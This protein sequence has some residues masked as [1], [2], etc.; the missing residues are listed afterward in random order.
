MD[1]S[2]DFD[3]KKFIVKPW[4]GQ[5]GPTFTRKF[6]P[7]FESALNVQRDSFS[8]VGQFLKGTDFGGWA[9]GAPIHIAGAGALAAQNAM[10]IQSRI[11]RGDSLLH[12][13]KKHILNEDI[14]DAIDAQMV[15]LVGAAPNPPPLGPGGAA[16]V[17]TLPTDWAMQLWLWIEQSHGQL[18]Q[19]GLLHSNQNDEWTSVKIT[20]VGIDRD[21]PRRLYGHLLRLNRARQNA[22]PIIEVWTK[23]LK[24]FT[25]P[26]MLNDM[27]LVQMQNPTY[28]IIGGPNAG[29]PDLGALVTVFEELWATI[30]NRGVEIKPQAP[31][32][33]QGPPSNRV[34][35]MHV[36]ITST[37]DINPNAQLHESFAVTSG[38]ETFPFLKDERN[39]WKC[40]GWGHT[41]EDCTSA[42]RP[43]PLSGCIQGLQE[44][45]S[46]QNARLRSVQAKRPQRR[47]GPSPGYANRA[48][49][50]PNPPSA[51]LSASADADQ[52]PLR[53]DLIEYDDGGVFTDQ[54][55]MVVE[56]EWFAPPPTVESNV[57]SGN[58]QSA[59]VQMVNGLTQSRVEPE[60]LAQNAQLRVESEPIAQNAQPTEPN[61]Q[62]GAIAES[63]TFTNIDEAIEREFQS[64]FQSSVCA[65]SDGPVTDDFVKFERQLLHRVGRYVCIASLA[66]GA[67]AAAV[68]STRGKALFLTLCALAVPARSHMIVPDVA[69]HSSEFSSRNASSY[70]LQA[71]S[72]QMPSMRHNA[73]VDSG[74]TECASGRRK[75]F[76]PSL[77]Q[78]RNPSV[79][80]E[81][82]SGVCLPVALQGG[83]AIK[84]RNYGTTS[85]KKTHLLIV[86]N[87]FF[88]PQMPVT[89]ISTKALFRYHGIRTYFNDELYLLLPDGEKLGFVETRNNYTLLIDDDDHGNLDI[90]REPS[91]MKSSSGAAINAHFNSTLR[92]P[93]PL[94]WT[95]A[96]SRFTHFSP[97]RVQAS[98]EYL[99]NSGLEKLSL[100]PRGDVPCIGCVKGGFRGHRRGHRPRGQFTRFGQRIYSDSC[101]MPKSTPF[102]YTY[103]YIFYDAY[104]KLI[105]VYFGKS[106]T[107]AEMRHVFKQFLADYGRYMKDGKVEEWY[108]DGGP[109]FSSDDTEVFCA[110]M[111]TRL[112]LIAPWNP[113]MNVAETGWR[114]ILRPL[115]ILIAASNVSRRLWP[116][117]VA[118]I[119]RVH[120]ALSTASASATEGVV[121]NFAQA[122]IA[123]LSSAANSSSPSPWYLVT[124]KKYDASLLRVMFCECEVRIRSKPD[125]A[126]REKT[127]PITY[128]AMHLGI[129]SKCVGF[130]VY[131]FC[132]HRFTTASFNDVYFRENKYPPLDVIVGTF[133]LGG[134]EG[135]LPTS[136]QQ[137][138]DTSGQQFPELTDVTP[139]IGTLRAPP[140]NVPGHEH[141]PFQDATNDEFSE[142]QCSDTRCQIPSTNGEHDDGDARH[143]YE[144]VGDD[145]PGLISGRTRKRVERNLAN[146][147]A[148][149]DNDCTGILAIAGHTAH[150]VI[151]VGD[152]PSKLISICYNVEIAEYG[153]VE[154]PSGT[155]QALSGP[156]GAEWRAAYVKDLEAKIA[157]GTFTY[158]R[159]PQS[160]R[161]IKTKVAHAIKRDVSTNA[162]V[163]LRGRWVGMG[164]LQGPGDFSETYCATPTAT[165]VRLF[166][167]FVLSLGLALAQGD[168]TK[169]FTLN[170][171]DVEMYV[172]QMPGMETAGDFPGAT[173]QNTVCLLHK[174]LEGLKQAGN[175]WQTAHTK[176]ILEF[177]I[178]KHKYRFI[179]SVVEPTLF[180]LHCSLGMIAMLVWVDDIL[181]GYKGQELYDAFLALYTA[182][183]P[184]KHHVGCT[185][186]A[187]LSVK[188]NPGVSLQIDQRHH[189]EMAY[190]KFV[191]DKAAAK[192][193]PS[194]SRIAV[195]D[196]DS[197]RHYSKITLAA[198]DQERAI[199]KSKPFLPALA[200][201]MYTSHWTLPHISHLCSSLG[202]FMHDASIL[203]Y[204]AVIEMIIYCYFN[205]DHDII[206]YTIDQFTMPRQIPES[207]R[208]LF[209][210]AMGLHGYSDASWQLRSVGAYIIMMCNGP[211]DWKSILI[212]VICHS[213][214][215]AEIAAG[216]FLGKRAVFVKEY[217]SEYHIPLG[218]FMLL[219]DNSAA[220]DLSKKLGVQ[221]RTAHFLRWQHYLRWLCLHQYVELFFVPTK[222]QLAD[223]LTKVLDMTAFLLFCKQVYGVRRRRSIA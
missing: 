186:F 164:F 115:R 24:M 218:T 128:T 44:L 134:R 85:A 104:S 18:Q 210:S 83:M 40:R 35:G 209:E 177:E 63:T 203:A 159:R 90:V 187:G 132:K 43:R 20:D 19:T 206:V 111:L 207:R 161:V 154:L 28:L 162:I 65:P 141:R 171:I 201:M 54:G 126:V 185:K 17:N 84:M 202:Q 89:L 175:V 205:R 135:H 23:Y 47:A 12:L 213:S 189:V 25:F 70:D 52:V 30:Y 79:K 131:I 16:I 179:Q 71:K 49:R 51:S 2:N 32:K 56:P 130:L 222:E 112:R 216:C 119:V 62:K 61:A 127:D 113:W 147:V 76:P 105:A 57:N 37:D 77:V 184:S 176:A 139:P 99:V 4:H 122:F 199:M 3:A 178:T 96:H 155:A 217:A 165:S 212:R 48:P 190:E 183:F 7:E 66:V 87:S 108:A 221:S 26:K 110:E 194:V 46:S 106:T 91:F 180:I 181:I 123:S 1:Q 45:Q 138:A 192:K 144:R 67:C 10:S 86:Q 73:I 157:N 88:V 137:D 191:T 74:T 170:P 133:E 5:R 208:S 152:D 149:L 27:A 117:G 68:R 114:I 140:M 97:T 145:R 195:S 142:K 8:S 182:R 101:A 174:C 173:K 223:A 75:L 188:Y 39:C 168:V 156:Q 42:A 109:E 211:V 21:T 120:N 163:E 118:Q 148:A 160:K 14:T 125:L 146:I 166:L 13:V 72:E 151:L 36:Q 215:E 129:D 60:P 29:Q 22:H 197:K 172:E 219:I 100:P 220:L 153:N 58:P 204:E 169:A 53:T 81:I 9:P 116:F 198:N 92:E 33:P 34:D 50:R 158:V 94:T 59:T 103:M 41:K 193:S 143:S 121:S 150:P 78:E 93:L 15:L 136:D 11:T 200:T 82:A 64:T 107:G 80:V 69:I 167:C 95:L 38:A 31:P 55:V 214:S 102:G 196:R 124:G 6:K 98:R